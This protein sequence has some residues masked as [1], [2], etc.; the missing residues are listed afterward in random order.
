MA[1]INAVA[2]IGLIVFAV[3]QKNK[4]RTL[5]KT[6]S[7]Q[8][9]KLDI[10]ESR[11]ASHKDMLLSQKEIFSSQNALL[12]SY[13]ETLDNVKNSLGTTPSLKPT[14]EVPA[15]DDGIAPNNREGMQEEKARFEKEVQE[16]K[17]SI[18]WYEKEF[19]IGLDTLLE[20]FLY[21]PRGIQQKIIADMPDSIIKKG[22]K[23]LSTRI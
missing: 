13:K 8:Q 19:S 23:R 16:K 3:Y 5:E 2:L 10:Q 22:F 11:L 4:I 12:T 20:L 9:E 14:V 6:L 21:V 7:A 18:D 15:A 1:W 17:K